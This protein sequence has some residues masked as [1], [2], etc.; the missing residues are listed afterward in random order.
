MDALLGAR[1]QRRASTARRRRHLAAESPRC[2]TSGIAAGAR[3]SADPDHAPHERLQHL[4]PQPLGQLHRLALLRVGG[5]QRRLGHLLVERADDVERAED[6]PARRA[7]S[8]GTVPPPNSAFWTA[9]CATGGMSMRRYSTALD[10]ERSLHRK[11][12]DARRDGVEGRGHGGASLNVPRT[13]L[14]V[15]DAGNTQTHL[16]TYRDGEL[17]QHWRF[18]T[19]R[20]STA[21]ELGAALRNLLALRGMHLEM[22]DGMIVSSTVPQLRPE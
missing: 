22:L 21:D 11:L 5:E 19:V 13:M 9:L 12:T 7:R 14:L 17:V 2:R 1:D 10:L 3:R 16:G 15:V 20:E 6:L 4:V 18:A 8:P